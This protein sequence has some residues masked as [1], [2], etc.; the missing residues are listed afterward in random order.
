MASNGTEIEQLLLE[1]LNS[2]V[3]ILRNTSLAASSSDDDD[4]E[5]SLTTTANR[6]ALSATIISV[7]AFVIAL[8]QAVLQYAGAN[9]SV[10]QKCN[11]AA[12]GV[13]SDYVRKR[14]SLRSWRR[15]FYYP[16]LNMNEFVIVSNKRFDERESKLV[17]W[18]RGLQAEG[19]TYSWM[20][21]INGNE[22]YVRYGTFC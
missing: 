3:G 4:N 7:A 17:R 16:E 20:R 5:N 9:E 19:I 1:A 8:L 14:W 13:W 2:L 12:I 11:S 22:G 10:R 15:K 21:S 6:L 18:M